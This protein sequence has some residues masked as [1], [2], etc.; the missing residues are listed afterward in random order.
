MPEIILSRNPGQLPSLAL[1][2]LPA[3]TTSPACYSSPRRTV[4]TAANTHVVWHR[5][6]TA[7]TFLQTTLPLEATTD[8][9]TLRH[10]QPGFFRCGT[11]AA[12]RHPSPR[13]DDHLPGAPNRGP[14]PTHRP[15]WRPASSPDA[16]LPRPRNIPSPN[17]PALNP[18]WLPPS[19]GFQSSSRAR[20]HAFLSAPAPPREIGPAPRLR[21]PTRAL[22]SRLLLGPARRPTTAADC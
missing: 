5:Q 10:V 20:A 2:D 22:P 18:T 8:A 12:S 19:R 3:P 14:P 7:P 1:R 16:Q 9:E 6:Q 11:R 21:A 4:Y 15:S 17:G 13:R